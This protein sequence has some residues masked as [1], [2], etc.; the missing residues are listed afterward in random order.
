MGFEHKDGKGSLFKNN[1]KT[2]DTQPNAKGEAKIGGVDYW[3]DAWTRQDKN[4]NPWQSLSFKRK[5][6][7]PAQ[8]AAKPA[9]QSAGKRGGSA[10]DDMDDDIPL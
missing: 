4:G 8:Q 5:D 3:V 2:K 7:Q 6:A 1:K 9:P 10:F